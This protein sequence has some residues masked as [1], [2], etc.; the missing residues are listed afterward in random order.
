MS[1]RI[2]GLASALLLCSSFTFAQAGASDPPPA[3]KPDPFQVSVPKQQ[4]KK[5]VVLS[6]EKLTKAGKLDIIRGM[7]AE[8]G[9]ARKPFPYGKTGITIK[10]NKIVNPTDEQMQD[11]MA[12]YGAALKAGDPA[13]ITAV[14]FKDKSIVFEVNGGPLRKQKWYQHIQVGVGDSTVSPG[15]PNEDTNI[16]GSLIE[17]QFDKYVPEVTPAQLKQLL[18]PIINFNAKSA[19]EAYLDTIPPKAKQAIGEHKALVGMDRDMVTY[20]LGRPPQKYRDKDANGVD[21]EEWIYGTP[22]QEVQ[23][24]RFEGEEVVRIETMKVDGTKQVRTEREITIQP[25]HPE[26]AQQTQP[27]VVHSGA[28]GQ[29][30]AQPTSTGTDASTPRPTLRRPGEDTSDQPNPGARP[31]YPGA[32]VPDTS[33][34]PG[35]QPPL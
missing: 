32:N 9:Y 17:L 16:H 12:S 10:D 35:Q 23:F 27:G 3:Q 26:V 31:Q 30:Q 2:F 24:V 8:L 20:A 7:T 25:N 28:P 21:Y 29:P 6:K 14:K 4:E 18:D 19:T 33:P 15:Q 11:M 13:H 22:P 34:D 1:S 5:P